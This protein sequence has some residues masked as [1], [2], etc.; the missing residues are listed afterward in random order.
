MELLEVVAGEKGRE[1]SFLLRRGKQR[2]GRRVE[3]GRENAPPP[4]FPDLFPPLLR[5]FSID[6]NLVRSSGLSLESSA[7]SSRQS[8]K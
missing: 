2:E 3:V 6:I 5:R 4:P 1:T 7:W 8:V